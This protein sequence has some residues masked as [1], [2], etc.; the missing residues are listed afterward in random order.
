MF[1]GDRHLHAALTELDSWHQDPAGR[2]ALEEQ[3]RARREAADARK[4]EDTVPRVHRPEL[5]AEPPRQKLESVSIPV[6]AGSRSLPPEMRGLGVVAGTARGPLVLLQNAN[7]GTAAGAIIAL[8]DGRSEFCP[9]LFEARGVV[10]LSGGFASP[11][12]LLAAELSLPTVL[13]TAARAL[14]TADVSIDGTSGT[15]QV[16]R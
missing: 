14:A 4:D 5:P 8:Q 11:V 9:H 16:R 2:D 13:C 10:L 15:I 3:W 6:R 12:A 1:K 7:R